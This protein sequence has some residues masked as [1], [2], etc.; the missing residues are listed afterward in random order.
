MANAEASSSKLPRSIIV[1]RKSY[2][3]LKKAESAAAST[4]ATAPP[5]VGRAGGSDLKS[6]ASTTHT[7][8]SSKRIRTVPR[9]FSQP[10]CPR[11]WALRTVRSTCAHTQPLPLSNPQHP[12]LQPTSQQEMSRLWNRPLIVRQQAAQPRR[13]A[14]HSHGEGLLDY[15]IAHPTR[16]PT[17]PTQSPRRRKHHGGRSHNVAWPR[18]GLALCP[19][20]RRPRNHARSAARRAAWI[21]R[22]T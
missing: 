13:L 7:T 12:P 2:D 18:C 17:A 16:L 10:P 5:A 4:P 11:I 8:A 9:K 1:R 22:G 21:A 14:T 6:P 19:N 20:E 15:A 3:A